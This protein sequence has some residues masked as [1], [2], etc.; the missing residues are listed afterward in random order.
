M[1]KDLQ[2]VVDQLI[3][4]EK[5]N[6]DSLINFFQNNSD[7]I[8]DFKEEIIKDEDNINHDL[9]ISYILNIFILKNN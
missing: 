2:Y 4:N 6:Y 3:H 5:F 8:H 9:I 7:L 1:K